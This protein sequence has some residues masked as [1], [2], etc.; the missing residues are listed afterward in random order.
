MRNLTFESGNTLTTVIAADLE[1]ACR[2]AGLTPDDPCA[3][4]EEDELERFC[5]L[6]HAHCFMV[7]RGV[8]PLYS[9]P[10]R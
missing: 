9:F 4:V 6:F 8:M 7:D 2:V 10:K 3:V 5:L 1:E